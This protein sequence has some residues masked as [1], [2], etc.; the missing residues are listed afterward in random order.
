MNALTAAG[1]VV[2][3]GFGEEELEE[4]LEGVADAELE[5]FGDGFVATEL[6]TFGDGFADAELE[7]FG[8]ETANFEELEDE[9]E[10]KPGVG[11]VACLGLEVSPDEAVE[12]EEL[13]VSFLEPPLEIAKI[14]TK[15]P[16]R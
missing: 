8:E 14:I 16:M 9:T 7:T 13:G 6:E 2:L 12:A 1:V 10:V 15:R 3:G 11:E 4:L 5:T